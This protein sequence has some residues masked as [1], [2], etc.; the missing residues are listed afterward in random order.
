[1]KKKDNFTQLIRDSVPLA[2]EGVSLIM[3]LN[4]PMNPRI[5]DSDRG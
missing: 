3:F 2:K 1:M 4:R 5:A